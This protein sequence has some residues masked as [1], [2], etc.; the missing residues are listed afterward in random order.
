MEFCK[1]LGLRH[2]KK[3]CK[4]ILVNPETLARSIYYL[5]GRYSDDEAME[6]VYVLSKIGV[7]VETVY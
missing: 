5:D 4:L 2:N 3:P 6:L 7:N 1:D